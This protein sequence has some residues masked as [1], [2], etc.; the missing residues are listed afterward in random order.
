[1]G[2]FGHSGRLRSVQISRFLSPAIHYSVSFLRHGD[3]LNTVMSAAG[4]TPG[5]S[6]SSI[7]NSDVTGTRSLCLSLHFAASAL[8][9][10]DTDVSS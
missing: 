9:C 7:S 5:K 8:V 1:M 6:K 3:I 2:K 4:E 10:H